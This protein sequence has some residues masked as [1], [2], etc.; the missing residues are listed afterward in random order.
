MKYTADYHNLAYFVKLHSIKILN[1]AES[2]IN[3]IYTE[4][5]HVCMKKNANE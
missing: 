2:I 4:R 5:K 3:I 1:K